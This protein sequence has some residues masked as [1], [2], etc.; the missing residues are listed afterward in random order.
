MK[1]KKNFDAQLIY[2]NCLTS[3]AF[4][5][6]IFSSEA[7][8]CSSIDLHSIKCFISFATNFLAICLDLCI[9]IMHIQFFNVLLSYHFRAF[10]NVIIRRICFVHCPTNT[11]LKVL[12][13]ILPVN[14]S[15]ITIYDLIKQ[16]ELNFSYCQGS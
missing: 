15:T 11:F 13:K 10:M 5:S 2:K 14:S 12:I 1:V 3:L 8:L 9:N 4:T 7:S 16:I 6:F